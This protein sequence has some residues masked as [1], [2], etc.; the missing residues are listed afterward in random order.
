MPPD[1][2]TNLVSVGIGEG[3]GGFRDGNVREIFHRPGLFFH[4]FVREGE[5]KWTFTRT[6]TIRSRVLFFFCV[7]TICSRAL[8]TMIVLAIE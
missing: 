5:G 6:P 1:F 4:N 2:P 3:G 7:G 8:S